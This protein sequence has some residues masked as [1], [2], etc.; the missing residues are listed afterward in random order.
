MMNRCVQGVWLG[1]RFTTDDHVIGL[2]NGKVVRT[3]NVRPM[4]LE[5]LGTW[6]RS[7]RSKAN[8]G[9]Q[10]S[11][12]RPDIPGTTERLESEMRRETE[13]SSTPVPHFQSGEGIL[14]HTGGIS[15]HSDIIDYTRFPSLDLRLGKFPDSVEFQSWK[16]NFKTEV[17]SKSVDLHLTHN[18]L[19]QRS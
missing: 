4:S 1:K 14:H 9:T 17:L 10:V 12:L 3:R 16:V 18:A 8:R 15:S 19:D 11:E 13:N 6:W 5:D 7:T 2:A